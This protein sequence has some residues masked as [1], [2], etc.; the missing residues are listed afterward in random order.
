[1]KEKKYLLIGSGKLASHLQFYFEN[2]SI[3]F[4]RWSRKSSN[5]LSE[6]IDFSDIIL[7][8]ISDSAID[9]FILQNNLHQTDK[10]LV[11]FSGAHISKYAIGIHPLMTFPNNIYT[12]E[13]YQKI[14][15]VMEKSELKFADIF[16]SLR[17]ECFYLDKNQKSEYHAWTSMAGNFTSMLLRDYFNFL[18]EKLSL[19]ASISH[20]Y[21]DKIVENVKN[22]PD[23]VTGPISRNDTKTINS[24]LNILEKN[25]YKKVYEGFLHV[26]GLEKREEL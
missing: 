10:L 12:A 23:P 4:S 11:H 1:M 26:S 3:D 13:F 15:F 2:Q 21:L 7:L 20:L 6:F 22:L 9:E 5:S 19:P 25:P 24:H 17:N 16:P 18:S 8:A 14:P